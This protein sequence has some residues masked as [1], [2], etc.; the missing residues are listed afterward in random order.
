[1]VH[2][3]GTEVAV[4]RFFVAFFAGECKAG[5][6]ALRGAVPGRGSVCGPCHLA[7][8]GLRCKD[9]IFFRHAAFFFV[10]ADGGFPGGT[11]GVP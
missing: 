5:A 11:D 1:M 7:L 9:M 3:A 2:V 8:V 6:G 4:A 10:R